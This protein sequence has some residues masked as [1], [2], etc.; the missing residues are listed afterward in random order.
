MSEQNR[1]ALSALLDDELDRP[2]ADRAIER[3][4][5]DQDLAGALA[6]YQLIGTCLRG[7][8]P[9]PRCLGVAAAV[10]SRLADEP[11]I[12][13]PQRRRPV[14]GWQRAAAGVAIAASVAAIAIGLF[15]RA[16]D[17]PGPG[18]AAVAQAPVQTA[19]PA[20]PVVG[21]EPTDGADEQAAQT[22]LAGY[23]ADHNE[24]AARGGASGFMP[25]TTLVTYD[26]R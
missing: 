11:A 7:E 4:L 22:A 18:P 21:G 20:L 15:P 23:L 1:E 13:A 19:V 6:R 25:Y 10:R 2:G 14:L 5:A 16:L 17:N 9:D 12:L 26:G 3:L 8:S 24:F